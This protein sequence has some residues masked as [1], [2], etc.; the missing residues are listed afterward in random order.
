MPFAEL[1]CVSFNYSDQ[2]ETKVLGEM[3]PYEIYLTEGKHVLT[4]E[5][6]VGEL[7]NTIGVL[8]S[9]VADLNDLYLSIMMITSSDPDPFRDYYLDRRIP[10][11]AQRFEENA[12][13]LFDEAKR[14]IEI[15]GKRGSESV[16][17]EDTAYQLVSYA[18]DH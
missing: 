15:T 5:N 16:L 8:Q 10:G 11:I 4:M 9:C 3:A 1:D 2:W 17:L 18:E 14:L 12:Q 7:D 13:L 6:V